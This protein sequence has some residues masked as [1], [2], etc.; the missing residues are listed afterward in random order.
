MVSLISHIHIAEV[1]IYSYD[2]TGTLYFWY[3]AIFSN[4]HDLFH[5]FYTLRS[6]LTLLNIILTLLDVFT[7]YDFDV[8]PWANLKWPY[9]A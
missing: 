9:M 7:I 1:L 8:Q 3:D 6:V 2:L 5:S 4:F